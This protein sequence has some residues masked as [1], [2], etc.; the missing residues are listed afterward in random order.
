MTRKI[1]TES[2]TLCI[3]VLFLHIAD[4]SNHIGKL[5]DDLL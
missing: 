1:Y 3:E 2:N 4:F 5:I